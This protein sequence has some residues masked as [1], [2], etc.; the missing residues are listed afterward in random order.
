VTE[1]GLAPQRT[2]LAWRRTLL[3]LTAVALLTIRLA[4]HYGV[5]GATLLATAAGMLLWLG[6]LLVSHRRGWGVIGSPAGAAAK[7]R[8][9]AA[10]CA[11]YA[12]LG[13]I[14]ILTHLPH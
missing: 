8:L 14:L 12:I 10:V 9:L 3:A 6:A 5:D 2:R 13:G 11:G 4:L 1:P 7:L